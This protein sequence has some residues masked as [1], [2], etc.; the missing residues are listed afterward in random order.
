MGGVGFLGGLT[1]AIGDASTGDGTG[2][3]DWTFTV[4][5]AALDKL[6]ADEQS[7]QVYDVTLDDGKGG[8]A[9]QQ[10]TITITGTNDAPV[11]G[12]ADGAGG[13]AELVDGD[14]QENAADLTAMGTIAS[15]TSRLSACQTASK[16]FS[17]A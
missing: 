1:A 17:S 9:T 16:P 14:P 15:R 5:D 12:V 4:N 13:V 3:V 7:V 11:I 2:R 10:V 6:A 8:S